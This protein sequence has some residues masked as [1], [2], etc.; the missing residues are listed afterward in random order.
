MVSDRVLSGFASYE[1]ATAGLAT[2]TQTLE[3]CM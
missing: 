1:V 2:E 3:A